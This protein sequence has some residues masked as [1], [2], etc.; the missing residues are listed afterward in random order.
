MLTKLTNEQ[1]DALMSSDKAGYFGPNGH[2]ITAFKNVVI[3]GK[4]GFF[5]GTSSQFVS[6]SP[7]KL[8]PSALLAVGGMAESQISII[9]KELNISTACAEDVLYLR[10]RERW[11]KDLEDKLIALHAINK[12]PN[13]LDFGLSKEAKAKI[14]WQTSRL[15]Q[16]ILGA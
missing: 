3:E 4:A 5:L 8:K 14:F 11:T 9:Q 6:I 2:C 12:P 1:A 13:M 16:K 15:K 7:P 10:T